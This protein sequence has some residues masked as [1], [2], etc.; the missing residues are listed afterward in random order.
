MP[1]NGIALSKTIQSLLHL[2]PAEISR[3]KQATK[4]RE[5]LKTINEKIK[6]ISTDNSTH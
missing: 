4:L 5:T 1:S 2:K 6:I 3:G